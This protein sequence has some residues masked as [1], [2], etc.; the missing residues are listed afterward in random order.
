MTPCKVSLKSTESRVDNY[1]KFING[2]LQHP[3]L[4]LLSIRLL[5]NKKEKS[6]PDSAGFP[7][8]PEGKVL[9][10]VLP[11]I[12]H[13]MHLSKLALLISINLKCFRAI[14]H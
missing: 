6:S 2:H 10:F 1:L 5:E 7:R 14:L 9:L 3:E 11:E 13:I 8:D 12:A 4:L